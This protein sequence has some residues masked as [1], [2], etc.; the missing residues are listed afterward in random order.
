M[1]VKVAQP[2]PDTLCANYTHIPKKVTT[3]LFLFV[4]DLASMLLSFCVHAGSIRIQ[5]RTRLGG[6]GPRWAQHP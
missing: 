1:R 3:A 6:L 5:E 2:D 4:G